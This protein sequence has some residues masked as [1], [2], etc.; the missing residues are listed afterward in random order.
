MLLGAGGA[1]T[2]LTWC[3]VRE[4]RGAERPN[5][6]VVTDRDGDRL[7]HLAEIAA[8]VGAD[9]PLELV[10]VASTDQTDAVLATQPAGSLVVNATGLGKDLPG[11]PIGED[12]LLPQ[13][14]IAWDLN[15]RGDL[16]FL[17][18]ALRQSGERSIRVEDGWTYFVH[19]WLQAV[20][21]VFQVDVPTSG[22]EF[23]R[24]SDLA[25]DAR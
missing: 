18:T 8:R 17:D 25:R 15:Y 9:V 5:R 24:L 7:Q 2:A 4:E 11:S 22:P 16:G 10:Q 20:K 23:D 1:G 19:G 6:L 21:E 12:A 13:D 3:L 14:A